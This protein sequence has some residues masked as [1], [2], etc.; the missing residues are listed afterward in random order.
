MERK[1]SESVVDV[2]HDSRAIARH[3]VTTP[4]PGSSVIPD[5]NLT[6]EFERFSQMMA[7]W[8]ADLENFDI[9]AYLAEAREARRGGKLDPEAWDKALEQGLARLSG[10]QGLQKGSR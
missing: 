4:V 1:S 10:R 9:S 5:V 8:R 7:D 3:G 6:S 2:T